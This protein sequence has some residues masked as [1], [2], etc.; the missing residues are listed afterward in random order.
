MN[1]LSGRPGRRGL[2]RR[3]TRRLASRARS[4]SA[5]PRELRFAQRCRAVPKLNGSAINRDSF[6]VEARSSSSASLQLA[7]SL[8]IAIWAAQ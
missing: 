5:A 3:P 2:R 8:S 6:R 4:G 7:T 1:K